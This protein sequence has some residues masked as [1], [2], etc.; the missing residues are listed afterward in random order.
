MISIVYEVGRYRKL[1]AD[2]VRHGDVVVEIGPH[3]GKSTD[4]Y[5]GKAKKAVLVDKG[6]DCAS[7]LKEYAQRHDN[8]VF[9]MGDARGFDCLSLV[10]KHAPRCDVLAVDLG[11]GRFPDTVFKVWGT[12]SGVLAPRDSIIRCRGLAEFV[13]R[14]RVDDDAIPSSFDDAGWL[15]DY[16][17]ATPTK[18]RDQLDEFRHWIDLDVI[19]QDNDK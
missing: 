16:G 13:R 14:A 4:A 15:R 3:V 11:G 12:W 7:C 9:V 5:V 6:K 1:L 10:L 17:R 2:T 8:A 19:W 18:L